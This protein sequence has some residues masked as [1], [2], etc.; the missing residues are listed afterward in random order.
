MMFKSINPKTKIIL[1]M[2]TWGTLGLFVRN[3]NMGSIEIA[4]F[5]ALIGSIFL[6]LI[7]LINKEKIDKIAL[8]Q[9]IGFLAL[10]G[11]AL[12]INWAALFQAM[13]YTTIANATLSYYLGPIFIIIFSAF[14]LKEKISIKN[15]IC[16]IISLLGLIMIL[17]SGDSKG[18]SDYNHLKGIMFGLFG[19]VL[20]AMI[21]ISNKFIKDLSPIEVTLSQLAISTLVLLPIVF[22]R[23]FGNLQGLGTNTWSLILILGIVHTGIAYLLYF[24]SLREVKSQTIAIVSYLDPITAIFISAIFLKEPMTMVQF[25][26]GILILLSAYINE[27]KD[28]KFIKTRIIE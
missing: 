15:L 24:P 26:G 7:V 16:I 21:V 5:R 12:G 3:I 18:L 11:I 1:A 23:G 10:S 20:Y 4:F 2:I 6:A 9:N 27:K 19:A 25:L 8:K 14:I 13:K 28:W 17:K 22:R